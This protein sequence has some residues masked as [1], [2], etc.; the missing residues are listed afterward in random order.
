MEKQRLANSFAEG[1]APGAG[2]A[3]HLPS[4]V[5]RSHA[6]ST[7]SVEQ[8]NSFPAAGAAFGSGF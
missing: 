1:A 2:S 6:T 4:G 3:E 5:V 7:T 8:T